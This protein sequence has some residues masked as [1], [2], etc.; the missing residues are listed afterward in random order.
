MRKRRLVF[1]LG[2]ALVLACLAT[3]WTLLAFQHPAVDAYERI[4]LGMKLGEVESTIGLPPGFYGSRLQQWAVAGPIRESGLSFRR[5]WGSEGP[6]RE[7]I[8]KEFWTWDDYWIWTAFDESGTLVGYYLI[9]SGPP[10]FLDRVRA[11]L[12]I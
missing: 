8:H 11:F 9:E 12:G 10:S 3:W 5:I 2:F 6:P 4:R 1:A 7:G